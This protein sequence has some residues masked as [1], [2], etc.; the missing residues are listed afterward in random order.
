LRLVLQVV[1]LFQELYKDSSALKKLE[2]ITVVLQYASALRA[3]RNEFAMYQRALCNAYGTGVVGTEG[4]H[5]LLYR[6][7]L[8]HLDLFVLRQSEGNS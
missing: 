4:V 5:T 7:T 3:S 6:R 8:Q 1:L 2:I